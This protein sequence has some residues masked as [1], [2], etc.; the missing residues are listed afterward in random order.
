MP[1]AQAWF[2][3]GTDTEVGKTFAACALLHA[4]RAGGLSTLAMKPVAAGVDAAGR[5]EDVERLI[6]ASARTAAAPSS[7]VAPSCG[8]PRRIL[9]AKPSICSL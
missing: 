6:A 5:N 2:L 9:S 4:A 1:R 8:L 3:T 7:T